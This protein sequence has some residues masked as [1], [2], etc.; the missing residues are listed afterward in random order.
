MSCNSPELLKPVQV[1]PFL[2]EPQHVGNCQLEALYN[3]VLVDVLVHQVAGPVQPL[4]QRLILS[5]KAY[6][7]VHQL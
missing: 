6:D 2:S 4:H 5:G 3:R 1:Q 7:P